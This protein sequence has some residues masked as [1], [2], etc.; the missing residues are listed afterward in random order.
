MNLQ[1]LNYLPKFFLW[2]AGSSIEVL[3][4]TTQSEYI[5][6]IGFGTLVIIPSIISFISS[7]YAISTLT[8]NPKIYFTVG[9]IWSMIVFSFDR[10]I[11]S[12]FRK[13]DSMLKDL[14]SFRFISRLIIAFFIG[15]VVSHPL[16]MFIFEESI[17]EQ[18]NLM[19]E[20]KIVQP[21]DLKIANI[22]TEIERINTELKKT[23]KSILKTNDLLSKEMTGTGGSAQAGVGPI[24]VSL[25]EQ[26][27]KLNVDLGLQNSIKEK[28]YQKIETLELSKKMLIE[29]ESKFNYSKDYLARATALGHFINKNIIVKMTYYILLIFFIIIDILPVTFKVLTTKEPYDY[30]LQITNKKVIDSINSDYKCYQELVK[31]IEELR[32]NKIQNIDK[33][34]SFTTIFKFDSVKDDFEYIAN[35]SVL[36]FKSKRTDRCINHENAGVSRQEKHGIDFRDV[37]QIIILSIFWSTLLY[38]ILE[39]KQV[40]GYFSTISSIITILIFHFDLFPNKKNVKNSDKP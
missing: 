10:F 31:K 29:D 36:S 18:L 32:I 30:K 16:V 8:E 23:R 33:D 34:D 5:K 13:E 15:I 24:A 20:E 7:S 1:T 4:N 37:L 17:S 35:E 39:N 6:H 38:L 40:V 12:T 2:C 9:I 22:H 28:L 19:R 21:Y 26:I 25:K 27:K 11:V 14:R 3:N